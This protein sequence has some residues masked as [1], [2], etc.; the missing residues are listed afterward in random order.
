MG[1][2]T[3]SHMKFS[4]LFT[5]RMAI[6][7]VEH[8]IRT[9][10]KWHWYC[11]FQNEKGHSHQRTSVEG[12]EWKAMYHRCRDSYQAVTSQK[13]GD[14]RRLKCCELKE[15]KERG[16]DFH[17]ASH[18][19]EINTRAHVRLDF[20]ATNLKNRRPHWQKLWKILNKERVCHQWRVNGELEDVVL[21]RC[22]WFAGRCVFG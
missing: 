20:W 2:H 4:L 12:P 16:V 7:T 1:I 19:K 6:R 18:E 5:M 3:T 14:T 21:C 17:A 11:Y 8:G 22:L 9:T 10:D 15:A 13:S